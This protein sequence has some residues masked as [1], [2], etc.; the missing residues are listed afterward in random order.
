ME[1]KYRIALIGNPNAGKSSIFN[2]LTGLRQK[3]ANFPGVTVDKKI[4]KLILGQGKEFDLIDFPGTYS[5]YPTT[6][7]EKVVAAILSNCGDED[8]PDAIIYIADATNIEKHLLLLTQ[9]KDLN[10]PIIFV[11]N[12]IDL[13]QKQQIYYDYQKLSDD[14]SVPVVPVSGKFGLNI[15]LLKDEISKLNF[16]KQSEAKKPFYT[17]SNTELALTRVVTAAVSVQSTY[18]ALLIAH[19]YQ[20]LPFLNN[21]QKKSIEQAVQSEN[22]RSIVNQ[23]EETM[24]RY[25]KFQVML[26]KAFIRPIADSHPLTE[27]IDAI[28]THRFLGPVIFFLTMFLVFQSIFTFAQYPMDWIDQG[29]GFLS[30][31]IKTNLPDGWFSSLLA[32]GLLAGL[33]GIVVFVPQIG[34]L[35]FLLT[36]LEETGYMARVVY[37]FDHL[38]QKFGLNGRSLIAMVSGGACAIPA[39]MSTRTIENR[40][41][42]LITILV[43]PLISCSA[44]IP[45]FAVLVAFVVPTDLYWLGFKAQGWIFTGLYLLGIVSSLLLAILLK[46]FIRTKETSSLMME[47]PDYRLPILRN[48]L[49]MVREKV[50]TFVV[51][52]GKVILAISLVLWLLSSFGPTGSMQNAELSAISKAQLMQMDTTETKDFI[53]SQKIEAS[54]AGI[55]GKWIEPAIKPLGFDWKIGIALITSFAAREVFVGT[56]ATIYSIGSAGDNQDSLHLKMQKELWPD[57][58][59]IYSAA[60]AISLLVFYVFAMQCMSTMAVVRRETKSWKWAIFQFVIMGIM[61]YVGSLI[62]F[63]LL[64]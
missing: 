28:L 15:N 44:R 8:F 7:D 41:E 52:A 62:C 23:I 53:A 45:V 4:G 61:A 64:K 37:M 20:W 5:L 21:S 6:S 60:T 29:V 19:H 34:I 16:S 1:K 13:S 26:K 36:L 42:R 17:L 24:K 12:M 50:M 11:L 18:Q 31:L 51:E 40:K 22:F 30:D 33:G 35:F 49:L 54:F 55:M 59:P 32:D 38:M 46:L 14:F 63:Q 57:G 39:I 56:M 2:Q 9:L 10:L 43:T 25:D 27:R 47:L 58:T 48:S 3:V